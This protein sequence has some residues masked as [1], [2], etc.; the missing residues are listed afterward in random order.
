MIAD[1]ETPPV[2]GL[3]PLP[4]NYDLGI[5]VPGNTVYAV[6]DSLDAT[7]AIAFKQRYGPMTEVRAGDLAEP[8]QGRCVRFD[9]R[10]DLR[11]GLAVRPDSATP[12]EP[13]CS[14]AF[15]VQPNV[16]SS[17][18]VLSAGHCGGDNRYHA[19][20][21]YG[22]VVGQQFSGR[23]D[24]ERHSILNGFSGVPRIYVSS[25]ERAREVRSVSQW[26]GVRVGTKVCKAGIRTGKTC[27]KITDKHFSPGGIDYP[28][29]AHRYV[30]T[31]Y[32]SRKGDSGGAVFRGGTAFGVHSGGRRGRC[33]HPD[34]FSVFAHIQY[35]QNALNVSVATVP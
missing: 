29:N 15:V 35:V 5:D 6:V 27:G 22:T 17:A 10:Y 13:F 9:C 21:F 32:C 3:L 33:S 25:R 4:E 12:D 7:T 1:R 20:E 24:A 28:T 19:G 26:E 18:Q 16:G 23:V 14:T 8:E 34:D 11:A 31:T 2:D 30:K